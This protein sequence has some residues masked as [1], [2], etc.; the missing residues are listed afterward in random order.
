MRKLTRERAKKSMAACW[1]WHTEWKHWYIIHWMED[2]WRL[3]PGG[4]DIPDDA[5][6]AF[7]VLEQPEPLK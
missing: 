5:F 4:P 6:S 3:F 2:A 1:G 7:R